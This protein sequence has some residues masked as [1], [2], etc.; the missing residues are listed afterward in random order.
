MFTMA[1]NLTT[2]ILSALVAPRLGHLSDRY[3]RTKLLALASCGGCAS[4]LI[5]ILCAKF[6]DIFHYNFLILAAT[7]DGLAGSF[8]A[9][10]ILSNSY[11][12]DCSPPSRR[13]VYFGRIHACI[14]LGLAVG[15]LLASYLVAITGS[16]LSVFY[17]TL[18]CHLFFVLFV[19]LV[20]P[21]SLSRRRRAI[22]Q[23]AHDEARA[24]AAAAAGTSSSDSNLRAS[25]RH[26]VA[27]VRGGS[28]FAPL[29]ALWPTQPGASPALRRNL[30]SFAIVDTILLG[31][32]M[33]VGSVLLLYC[34]SENT[35]NWGTPESSR[36]ISAVSFVRVIV[37]LLLLPVVNYFFRVRPAAR[38]AL[39]TGISTAANDRNA[40]ADGVDVALIR[41]ALL[42]DLVGSLGYLFA[43]REALFVASGMLTAVGGLG[44]ATVQSAA[45]KHV[46]AEQVGKLLGAIGLLQ[47]LS[48]VVG[49]IAFNSLYYATV[50]KFDQAIFALLAGLFGFAFVTSWLIRPHGESSGLRRSDLMLMVSQ[51][52]LGSLRRETARRSPSSAESI[53]L[54]R[55]TLGLMVRHWG[56]QIDTRSTHAYRHIL[57][58]RRRRMIQ[59]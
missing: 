6:P 50:G 36:F 35:W 44:S 22:A 8:T 48:R 14:F 18:G 45:T 42:S 9:G 11:T 40:G 39:E 16:L 46:P 28:V 20:V 41:V 32:A 15:P 55:Y 52:I 25:L 19:G 2:G 7:C 43:R 38:R 23:K 24:E 37:L 33:S 54:S 57:I 58:P 53:K 4:E 5:F 30:V 21:E 31:A 59:L 1:I 51:C 56:K 47:A 49:P 3:G 29:K 34:E 12:S 26:L 27:A 17:V 13:A 10:Q